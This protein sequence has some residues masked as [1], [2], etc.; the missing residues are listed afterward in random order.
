MGHRGGR[1]RRLLLDAGRP[2]PRPRRRDVGSPDLGQQARMPARSRACS[3]RERECIAAP[4]PGAPG[5]CR[6][7]ER[8]CRCS[9]TSSPASSRVTGCPSRGTSGC[10]PSLSGS[11]TGSCTDGTV[12]GCRAT[13]SSQRTAA[14][15]ATF[16]SP[17]WTAHGATSPERQPRRRGASPPASELADH[18]EGRQGAHRTV[19][20]MFWASRSTTRRPLCSTRPGRPGAIVAPAADALWST[21]GPPRPIVGKRSRS[22]NSGCVGSAA[23]SPGKGDQ[24]VPPP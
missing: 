20:S 19:Q 13:R 17:S 3:W 22:R 7:R 1:A 18:L 16:T 6:S 9:S 11:G 12:G 23:L 15:L 4:R 10:P 2:G 8:R 24:K 5:C 21:T 14:R